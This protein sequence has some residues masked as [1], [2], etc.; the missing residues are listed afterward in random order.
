[1]KVDR[2]AANHQRIGL[3][4]NV[5]IYLFEGAG[6]EAD[7]AGNLLDAIS[8]GSLTAVIATLGV[9]EIV[10]GAFRAGDGALAER[11]REELTS[12]DGLDFIPL[13]VETGVDAAARRGAGSLRLADAIHL[14]TA[15]AAGA[16]A[17]VTNDRS[18]RSTARL[19]LVPLV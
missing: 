10:T 19:E 1:M 4:S 13:R 5:F 6:P 15:R 17:F 2:L 11:Y 12:I 8:A 7:A 16:T 18:L 9:A 14:A 3:D